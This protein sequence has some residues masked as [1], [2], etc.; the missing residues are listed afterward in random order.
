[1]IQTD[2]ARY[3]DVHWTSVADIVGPFLAVGGGK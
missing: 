1:M 2:N 3:P